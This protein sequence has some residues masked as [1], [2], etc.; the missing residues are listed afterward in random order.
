MW[1][2]SDTRLPNPSAAAVGAS[3]SAGPATTAAPV[4]AEAAMNVRR[5]S[6]EVDA[7]VDSA[8]GEHGGSGSSVDMRP[9]TS[10]LA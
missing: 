9:T 2:V 8:A 6:A 4:T 1:T 5:G 10:R 7:D 3:S